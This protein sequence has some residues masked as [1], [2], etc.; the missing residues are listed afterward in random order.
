MNKLNNTPVFSLISGLLWSI[1]LLVRIL[2]SGFVF[3]ISYIPLALGAIFFY[4]NA[5]RL[6]I[7]YKS[8]NEKN[9]EVDS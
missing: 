4:G 2:E 6:K 1:T 9:S 8:L 5:I 7:K 3:N